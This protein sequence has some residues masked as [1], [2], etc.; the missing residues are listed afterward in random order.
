[1]MMYPYFDFST[2]L[3]YTFIGLISAY[4]INLSVNYKPNLLYPKQFGYHSFYFLFVTLATVRLVT[5]GI[6]GTDAAG[7]ENTFLTCLTSSS[8]FEDQE[9][10]FGLFNKAIRTLTDNPII[11]RFVCYS[12]I[13]LAYLYFIKAFCVRGV[14]CIPFIVLMIPYLKSFNTMRSSMAISVILFG[15]VL[16]NKRKTLWGIVMIC[17]SVFIHRM[18]IL[19][20]L[21][22]P[23]YAIFK[24]YKYTYSNIK[25]IIVISLLAIIGYYLAVQVQQYAIA[26]SLLDGADAYYIAKN[27]N[28]SILDAAITVIPLILLSTMWLLCN[29]K[30]KY[31]TNISFLELIVSFDLIITPVANILGMWR[32]NEYFYL[33]RLVFWAYLIPVFCSGFKVQSRIFTKIT[34]ALLFT[35]WLIYRILREWEPCGLMPYKLFFQ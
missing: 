2:L 28:G 20:V 33:G 7:Y 26:F 13:T 1:M 32:A 23:F 21:F 17:M 14:S 29:K 31:D 15:L 16:L 19:Y 5:T 35:V 11:Y 18:S 25:L 24:H 34:F 8:R 10:I 3:L 12:I 30:L 9:I 4:F 22:L 6:V 27:L